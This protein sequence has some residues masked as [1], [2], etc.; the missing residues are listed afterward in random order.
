MS[1]GTGVR[2][3]AAGAGLDRHERP[4]GGRHDR[5]RARRAVPHT[6]YA[7]GRVLAPAEWSAELLAA[8]ARRLAA[9]HE[10]R[11]AS[12]G[13]IDPQARGEIEGPPDVTAEFEESLGWWSEHHPDIVDVPWT[14][15]LAPLAR[16]FIAR[17]RPAF[18]DVQCSFL[19]GD[20]TASNVVVDDGVPWLI[21]WEWAR[22]GEVA[23][24]LALIG[25]A[26]HGG[27]WYVPMT[28]GEVSAFVGEYARCAHTAADGDLGAFTAALE[29]RREAWE[30]C[31]RFASCLRVH[32]RASEGA[33]P[34][35][36][37][38]AERIVRTLRAQV[39]N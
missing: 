1:D 38:A 12:A 39:M 37:S 15:E 29:R 20:L 27:P 18:E 7:P 9:F 34:E 22:V 10:R 21:D 25:G 19:H 23:Y 4:R 24:D 14:R 36:A 2:R 35:Y 8:L 26:V 30:V 16:A 5:E 33:G 6:T 17:R 28:Q 32:L 11:Y 3:A 13:P 31:E